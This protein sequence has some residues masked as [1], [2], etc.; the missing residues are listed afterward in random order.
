MRTESRRLA[1]VALMVGAVVAGCSGDDGDS[2]PGGSGASGGSGGGAAT[3]GTGGRT[4]GGGMGGA[5]ADGTGGM[6]PVCDG[7]PCEEDP[8]CIEACTGH[9]QCVAAEQCDCDEGYAGDACEQCATGYQPDPGDATECSPS[10]CEPDPCAGTGMTCD[11]A[12]GQCCAM[13]CTV[14][15]TQCTAGQQ[16]LCSAPTNGCSL[17]TDP[18]DCWEGGCR[19]ATATDPKV[20]ISQWGGTS[21]NTAAAV[22]LAADGQALVTGFVSGGF[23]DQPFSSTAD[24]YFHAHDA[25]ATPGL[26]WSA[27]W[28]SDGAEVARAL[29][30]TSDGGVVVAGSME[31]DFDGH[32]LAGEADASLTKWNAQGELVWSAQWGTAEREEVWGVALAASGAFYVVGITSGDLDGTNA[33]MEDA[34]LTRV[35]A[36]GTVEWSKQWGGT[37]RDWGLAIAIDATGNL[38]VAGR[39]GSN[40]VLRKLDADGDELWVASWAGAGGAYDVELLASGAIAVTGTA[41]STGFLAKVD[42]AGGITWTKTFPATTFVVGVDV[43]PDGDLYIAGDTQMELEAGQQ[44]GMADLFVQRRD[45]GTGD[46]VWTRQFGT[47]VVERSEDIA[48]AADG[49]IYVV[50]E[51]IGGSFPG[52]VAKGPQDAVL[53]MMLP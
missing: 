41:N 22:A 42:S 32:S 43:G 18:I 3:G 51:T 47:T 20:I 12:T 46:P 21:G 15:A 48:V 25:A 44:V 27:V 23:P 28:G 13:T 49:T 45:V 26:S 40:A 50:G 10:L 24:M 17:F 6:P 37:G 34:Y 14:G 36:T 11:E 16:S 29:V 35:S 33:G 53:L 8:T 30:P 39:I 7:G 2:G 1:C 5:S 4:A 9:G 31:G 38:F 19:C 52:F